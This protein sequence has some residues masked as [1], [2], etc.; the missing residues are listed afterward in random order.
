MALS[1]M[2]AEVSVPVLVSLLKSRREEDV[3]QAKE[4]L[5]RITEDD[6]IDTPE[7]AMKWLETHPK[8]PAVQGDTDPDAETLLEQ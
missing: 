2:D 1:D 3:E 4:Y 8:K 6:S 7:A 5:E